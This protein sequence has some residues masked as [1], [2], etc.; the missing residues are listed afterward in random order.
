MFN[1]F[2]I[3]SI[4]ESEISGDTSSETGYHLSLGENS[5]KGSSYTV[6]NLSKSRFLHIR[7]SFSQG[8]SALHTKRTYR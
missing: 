1:F 7:I 5:T 3:P 8:E 2:A 6:E 4:F